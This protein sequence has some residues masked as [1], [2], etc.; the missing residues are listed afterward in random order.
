[1]LLEMKFYSRELKKGTQV[2][3]LLPEGGDGPCKVLWLLHGLTDDHTA[4]TRYTSIERYANERRLAVVMPGADRSWYTNT[5]YGQR[6]LDFVADEVPA[7]CRGYFRGMSDAREDNYVGGLSMGG[8]GAMKLSLLYPERYAGCISLS[9]SLDITRK[10]RTY[11]LEEWRG[12]FGFDI[13]DAFALEGSEHDLF[14][15]LDKVSDAKALPRIFQWC[16]TEDTLISANRE[17][18]DKLIARG[19]EVDYSESEGNHSWRWWDMHI[20]RGLKYLF[21]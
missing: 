20:Q 12:N 17:F 11:L 9:G 10:N 6:Y 4:W 15:L 19:A 14:A 3:V 5:A 1:M 21:G 7:V 2:N 18:R 13:P 8:Y 16:G